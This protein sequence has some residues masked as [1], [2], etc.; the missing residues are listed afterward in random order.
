[1]PW[2]CR[3]GVIEGVDLWRWVLFRPS[4]YPGDLMEGLADAL[5]SPGALPEIGADGT[6]SCNSLRSC[7]RIPKALVYW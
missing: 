7:K 1:M 3:P 4:D 6:D 2:L 5:I